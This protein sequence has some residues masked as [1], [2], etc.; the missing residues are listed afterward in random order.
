MRNYKD[1]TEVSNT[2]NTPDGMLGWW[3]IQ[4]SACNHVPAMDLHPHR[5][6]E[7]CWCRPEY[8]QG[9]LHHKAADGREK[10]EQGAELH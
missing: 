4:A 5:L 9:C 2:N 3:E 1:G 7:V 8:D 6:G 10:Y